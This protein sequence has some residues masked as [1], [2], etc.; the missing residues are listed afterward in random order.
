[1]NQGERCYQQGSQ[2]EPHRRDHQRG[3]AVGLGQ[4]RQDGA[5]GNRQ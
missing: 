1:M 5:E 3:Y 4:T 2:S